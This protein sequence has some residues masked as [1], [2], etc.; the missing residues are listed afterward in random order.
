MPKVSSEVSFCLTTY[1]RN[2]YTEN[3]NSLS[4]KVIEHTKLKQT[5]ENQTPRHFFLKLLAALQS[6]C[7]SEIA[8]TP[9]MKESAVF[10]EQENGS[11]YSQ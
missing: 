3:N 1:M 11:V 5:I 10:T 7:L 4:T 9:T 6:F 8:Q 2:F